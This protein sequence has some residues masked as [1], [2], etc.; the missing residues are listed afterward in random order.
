MDANDRAA[1][2]LR[3]LL[4]TRGEPRALWADRVTE[5][6]G[7]DR[8]RAMRLLRSGRFTPSE[9]DR[10]TRVCEVSTEELRFGRL[11]PDRPDLILQENLRYLLDILEH[12]EQKRLAGL[13]EMETGTV[14]RWRGGKQLPERKTQA[15]LARYFGLPPGT[16]LQA[17]PVF[18]SYPPADERQRRHWLR[19]RIESISPDL[20]GEL[21]PALERLLEDE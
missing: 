6:A 7:C 19:E 15:A 11:V 20:L 18:L 4:F 17:D 21:F 3:Y 2:N 14:S 5:W 1:E 9:Q 13:L 8:R 12:G 10:I 16:D